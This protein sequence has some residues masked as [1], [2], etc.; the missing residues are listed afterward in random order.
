MFKLA[1]SRHAGCGVYCGEDGLYLAGAPLTERVGRSYRPRPE[2]EIGALLA[3]AYDPAPETAVC[4]RGLRVVAEALQ[5]GNLARA[6]IAALHLRLG[7]I[8]EK[9][10]AR[11]TRAERLLKFNFNPA[12]PRD[13]HGRW[14]TEG[15]EGNIA[16]AS[17]QGQTGAPPARAWEQF[18]NADFRNRLATAEDAAVAS[19]PNFGYGRVNPGSGALGR[20]Q[21]L[22]DALR[23]AGMTDPNGNW[24]GKYG[25]N[26]RAAFLADPAAQEQALTV[27]LQRTERQLEANGALDFIGTT[28]KGLVS[29]FTVTRAGL[30]AAGHREGP[31][32][33]HEYLNR[34]ADV[35]YDS[36]RL[37]HTR[38]NLAIE[39]RLRTFTDAPYE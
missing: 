20:Y 4:L 39:T 16:P 2:P 38:E 11:L 37:V 22:A 32:A 10:I 3:A 17:A 24:T 23:E 7:D 14:T 12:E 36:H 31:R 26:S 18:P 5:E 15:G 34:L 8:S 28:V 9:G 27:L 33:T 1:D 6:M 30:I 25:V 13:W 29:P 35:G 19:R 21:M